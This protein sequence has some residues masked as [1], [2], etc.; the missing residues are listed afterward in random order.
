MNKKNLL[1]V[2]LS[3][4]IFCSFTKIQQSAYDLASN[5]FTVKV[6]TLTVV[7]MA[8]GSVLDSVLVKKSNNLVYKV[9][10]SSFS[11]GSV[12]SFAKTD[13]YGVISSVTNPTTTPNYTSRVDTTVITTKANSLTLAQLQTR[14]N[15]YSPTTSTGTF[16]YLSKIASY[17]VLS[18]D[19]STSPM[20]TITVNATSGNLTITLPTASTVAGKVINIK[21]LDG[22][23]NTVTVSGSI[24]GG[25][26]IAI[27]MQNGN[28]QI[29]SI[30]T[31]YITL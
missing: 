22:S 8:E 30:S 19:W 23:V 28:L 6:R 18:S 3:L 7:G 11:S 25:S 27:P 20:L 5:F 2:A 12:T 21:R 26:S 10:R 17:T 1:V 16:P 9:P 14:F 31:S 29:Q 24:D 15:L 4:V 13:G